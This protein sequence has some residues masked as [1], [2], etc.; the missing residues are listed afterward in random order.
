MSSKA[1]LLSIRPKYARKI[2]AGAKKVELRRVKPN[3]TQGDIV[4]VYVSSP[5]QQIWGTFEVDRVIEKP[6]DELWTLVY[7]DA[8]LSKDEFDNYY[9]SCE[10]GCGIYLKKPTN[11][12]PINLIDLKKWW[13]GFHP[14]QSYRYLSPAELG[15]MSLSNPL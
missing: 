1:I 15:R 3:L 14:P 11:R 10:R 4:V 8:G 12:V 13:S 9:S 7:N 2:F 6:I 5:I